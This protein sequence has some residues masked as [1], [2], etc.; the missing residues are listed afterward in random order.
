[1]NFATLPVHNPQTNRLRWPIY[2]SEQFNH[3]FDA[4]RIGMHFL[5][6]ILGVIEKLDAVLHG[7][8]VWR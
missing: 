3:A 5:D 6:D 4:P 1:M 2:L 8:A 7:E